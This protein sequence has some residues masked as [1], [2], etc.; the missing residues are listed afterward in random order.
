MHARLLGIGLA[1]GML[2]SP[3]MVFAADA[4]P[5]DVQCWRNLG[6]TE[7]PPPGSLAALVDQC[8]KSLEQQ[9]ATIENVEARELRKRVLLSRARKQAV[10]LLRVRGVTHQTNV[11]PSPVRQQLPSVTDRRTLINISGLQQQRRRQWIYLPEDVRTR[12]LMINRAAARECLIRVDIPLEDCARQAIASGLQSPPPLVQPA[13]YRDQKLVTVSLNQAPV[14]NDGIMI[15]MLRVVGDSRC[16]VGTQCLF[17]GEAGISARV[18]SQAAIDAANDPT[19]A[20]PRTLTIPGTDPDAL[21][22]PTGA[23]TVQ[24]GTCS[25]AFVRLLP[26]PTMAQEVLNESLITATFVIV[27][28]DGQPSCAR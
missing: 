8:V 9:A 3:A 15:Q 19:L 22:P 11:V 27:H 23:N 7:G 24:V 12:A 14:I 4:V 20:A 26:Y 17:S 10:P 18:F 5:F 21:A 6:L 28:P 16:L 2:L 13:E 1:F 25:V